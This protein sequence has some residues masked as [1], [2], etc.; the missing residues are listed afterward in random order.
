MLG[1][2]AS[3]PVFE[4]YHQSDLFGKI[5]FI[6]L[7][8]LSILTW[9]LFLQKWLHQKTAKQKANQLFQL[10]PKIRQNP[11]AFDMSSHSGPFSEIY[12]TLKGQTLEL[13]NKNKHA[14]QSDA[15]TYLSSSDI[16]LIEAQLSTT[17]STE[18][19]ALE[20]NLFVLSTIV[21][22]APFLGLL[23]TVWGILVTF[24]ELQSGASSNANAAVMGGL[25][26]ALGTTVLGLVVAIPALISYNYLR[27]SA[28]HF[29]ADMEDFSHLLLSSV[30]LHYRKVDVQP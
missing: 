16:D 2:L 4:A 12:R 24:A 7:I 21:S 8:L 6:G 30:E 26:M 17:V 29:S 18:S 27:S 22:L 9:G 14:L 5:I 28:A 20:K 13:L 3:N 1:L 23:G 19:K 11:L 10:L 25:A 15:P